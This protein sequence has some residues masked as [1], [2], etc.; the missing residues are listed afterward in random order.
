MRVV[1]RLVLGTVLAGLVA[2]S[3]TADEFTCGTGVYAKWETSK[4]SVS[5]PLSGI[6][7]KLL[8]LAGVPDLTL[9]WTLTDTLNTRLDC[10]CLTGLP[11]CSGPNAR[12]FALLNLFQIVSLPIEDIYGRK[13]PP[14]G[15]LISALVASGS[16]WRPREGAG[17]TDL[18]DWPGAVE[19]SVHNYTGSLGFRPGVDL[20]FEFAEASVSLDAA[21]T[22]QCNPRE[23]CTE[24]HAP[25]LSTDPAFVVPEGE[26]RE[27]L[28]T[29]S[30]RR[31]DVWKV[32][33]S[34][35]ELGAAVEEL[36]YDK[37]GRIVGAKVRVPSD[38]D[39]IVVMATD[40]CDE[41]TSVEVPVISIH[42]PKITV[43]QKE[44]QQIRRDKWVYTVIATVTD[45]DF[46]AAC[47][48]RTLAERLRL[49]AYSS[50]GGKFLFAHPWNVAEREVGCT[51]AFK[52]DDSYGRQVKLEYS[53]SSEAI[54]RQFMLA[55]T[56]TDAWGF[57]EKWN[58]ELKDGMPSFEKYESFPP[59]SSPIRIPFG[60]QVRLTLSFRDPDGDW[61]EL[62]QVRG[63]GTFTP[64]QGM[65]RVE[66]TWSWTADSRQRYWLV[67]FECQDYVFPGGPPYEGP[68][69]AMFL[70]EIV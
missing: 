68:A 65:G 5:L 40:E 18:C 44:W 52:L 56:A 67:E 43:N 24:E 33:V 69:R 15:K 9:E 47:V 37:Q 54:P 60:A 63:P 35:T 64:V 21:G 39:S 31:G 26:A 28:V 25:Q 66:G 59:A 12:A 6:V 27:F 20:P 50:G 53:P 55:L 8:K 34:K 10:F 57:S 19:L 46:Y 13:A 29:I 45:R 48:E 16:S 3:G 51:D 41:S 36:S 2:A 1:L 11:C 61:L 23:G 70:L 32:S 22:C 49:S 62:R 30:D 4:F 58:L 14:Q 7:A 38:L 17:G 42:R